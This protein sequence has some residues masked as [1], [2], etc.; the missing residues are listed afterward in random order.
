MKKLIAALVAA[1]TAAALLAAPT[2]GAGSRTV[3][4]KDNRFGPRTLTIHRGT[5]VRWVWRGRAP[6]NVTVTG[7][8]SRFRSSTK[9]SGSYRHRFTKRGTYRILCTIH[10]PGMRMTVKVS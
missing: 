7:G 5:T 1:A 8:P 10:A 2:L 6:H 3:S 4:V 9:T